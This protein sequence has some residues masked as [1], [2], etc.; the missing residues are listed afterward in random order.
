MVL[1]WN[2]GLSYKEIAAVLGVKEASV[3][4]LL[5]RARREFIRL[6]ERE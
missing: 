2:E 6:F 4:T 3:G 1:L 5:M